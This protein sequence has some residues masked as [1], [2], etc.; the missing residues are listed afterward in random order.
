ME[1]HTKRSRKEDQIVEDVLKDMDPEYLKEHGVDVEA[2]G[3]SVADIGRT[4]SWT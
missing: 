2:L 3:L 1:Q 4:Y